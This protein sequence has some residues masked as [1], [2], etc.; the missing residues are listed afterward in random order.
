MNINANSYNKGVESYQN[1]NYELTIEY[2]NKA[3]EE[4]PMMEFLLAYKIRAFAY[5][6]IGKR[7]EAIDDFN[8]T[9][10]HITNEIEIFYARGINYKLTGNYEKAV[11]D[12]HTCLRLNYNH[13]NTH[14]N[15]Q[16]IYAEYQK[17]DKLEKALYLLNG[18]IKIK[19]SPDAVSERNRLL[20]E[21]DSKKI[22]E[23]KNDIAEKPIQS[24]K[25]EKVQEIYSKNETNLDENKKTDNESEISS[26]I[27][28]YALIGLVLF[29]F[30]TCASRK[31]IGAKCRDGTIRQIF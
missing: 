7:K 16:K 18:I 26:R 5:S 25:P 21:I 6:N 8:F 4:N 1:G 24:V 30:I 12:F 19:S 2:M 29:T 10:K 27:L 20:K 13:D 17:N 3:M 14:L 23:Q 31:R 11:E 9:L 22:K 15:L 28:K